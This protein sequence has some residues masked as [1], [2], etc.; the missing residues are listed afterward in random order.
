MPADRAR[1]EP[2]GYVRESRYAQ[3][4]KQ[5]REAG[6]RQRGRNYGRR[7]PVRDGHREHHDVEHH[8]GL[9]PKLTREEVK[10]H[11]SVI[12][13]GHRRPRISVGAARLLVQCAGGGGGGREGVPGLPRLP[14][15]D[16]E[17]YGSNREL[18]RRIGEA[19]SEIKAGKGFLMA[20][21][22]YPDKDHPRWDVANGCG[23]GCSC[24]ASDSGGQ[25]FRSKPAKRKSGKAAKK[26]NGR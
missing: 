15:F 17:R 19:F 11:R 7:P 24:S 13:T 25:H 18:A 12:F 8:E 4:S 9:E 6:Q 20:W 21:R 14:H 22:I 5:N 23:C 26:R 1:L 16:T 3:N 10:K 2:A